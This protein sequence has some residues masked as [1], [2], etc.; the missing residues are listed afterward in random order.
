MLSLIVLAPWIPPDY[1]PNSNTVPICE[2]PLYCLFGVQKQNCSTFLDHETSD[3]LRKE[4][5]RLS[6][7]DQSKQLKSP[8]LRIS[9]HLH[10]T[11]RPCCL[12]T[13]REELVIC[14][15]QFADYLLPHVRP[16]RT[17]FYSFLVLNS[18]QRSVI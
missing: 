2:I 11:G 3:W 12:D 4:K 8:Y 13:G 7:L 10:L 6:K 5:S 18:L 17:I 15:L 1:D 14:N 16:L 9:F